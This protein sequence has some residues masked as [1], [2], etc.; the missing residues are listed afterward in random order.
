MGM[1]NDTTS[2]A[3]TDVAGL[4]PTLAPAGSTTGPSCRVGVTS[5]QVAVLAIALGQAGFDLAGLDALRAALDT[6]RVR[7]TTPPGWG[8]TE[9]TPP[10]DAARTHAGD[11]KHTCNGTEGRPL[12]FG[13]IL[14]PSPATLTMP[15]I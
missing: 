7:M 13:R 15:T 5:D 8:N 12:P 1:D 14:A 9:W 3:L 6:A 2:P 11:L 4:I 10:A